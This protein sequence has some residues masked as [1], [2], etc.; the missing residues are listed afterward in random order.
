MQS[1]RSCSLYHYSDLPH[2][3]IASRYVVPKDKKRGKRAYDT[4]QT[5]CDLQEK[6]QLFN[7]M[8][9]VAFEEKI[10]F[11]TVCFTFKSK[12]C[13]YMKTGSWVLIQA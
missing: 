7:Q 5:V 9:K 6:Q 4:E 2:I 1:T 13:G 8:V 3:V 10:L 12:H 11:P